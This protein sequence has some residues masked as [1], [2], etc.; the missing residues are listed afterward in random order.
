MG[1]VF[2]TL[3]QCQLETQSIALSG[4]NLILSIYC[5]ALLVPVWLPILLVAYDTYAG[6]WV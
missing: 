5:S 4:S 1:V 3:A 6:Q 2:V